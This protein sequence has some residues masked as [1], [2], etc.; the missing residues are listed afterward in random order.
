MFIDERESR[1]AEWQIGMK[2]PHYIRIKFN[3][4]VGNVRVIDADTSSTT[5]CDCDPISDSPCGPDTDCLNR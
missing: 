5:P 2:P 3:R 4:P 1:A